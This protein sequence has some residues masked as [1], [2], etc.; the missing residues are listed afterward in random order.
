MEPQKEI[1][2]IAKKLG[3]ILIKKTHMVR[4]QYDFKIFIYSSK[5]QI[6]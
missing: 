6:S 5:N 2:K 1:L 3:F 4:C